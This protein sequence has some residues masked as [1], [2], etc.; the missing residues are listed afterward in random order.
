VF[1]VA[2]WT[3][4]KLRRGGVAEGGD[5]GSEGFSRGEALPP[6]IASA[7]ETDKSSSSVSWD[8]SGSER[9]MTEEL[10]EVDDREINFESANNKESK[11][12]G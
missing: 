6:E 5:D 2:G 4:S 3:V 1:C 7:S 10:M 11:L 9:E 12:L 8:E